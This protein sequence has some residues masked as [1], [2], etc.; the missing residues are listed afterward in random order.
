MTFLKIINI[1]PT[2]RNGSF[3]YKGLN[4][5]MFNPPDYSADNSFCYVITS[6]EEIPVHPDVTVLTEDDYQQLVEEVRNKPIYDPITELRQENS[7]LKVQNSQ[8]MLALVA[9]DLI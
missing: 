9:N 7:E 2:N 6:E 1:R 5:E 3:D 8:I 4:T